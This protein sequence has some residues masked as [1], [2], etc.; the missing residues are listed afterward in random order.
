MVNINVLKQNI[1]N[2]CDK[3]NKINP[4]EKVKVQGEE[5]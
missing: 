3:N 1:R 4:V 2:K 5:I